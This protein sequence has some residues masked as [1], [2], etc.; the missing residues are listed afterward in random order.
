MPKL[1]IRRRAPSESVCAKVAA[2]M[3]LYRRRNGR[4]EV[5]N[6]FVFPCC[7]RTLSRCIR[8]HGEWGHLDSGVA[9]AYK[10]YVDNAYG[11]GHRF[12][13]LQYFDQD[14]ESGAIVRRQ[15]VARRHARGVRTGAGRSPRRLTRPHPFR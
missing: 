5:R 9:M 12:E 4:I 1:S 14:D 11:K 7:P 6:R 13:C 10:G 2:P 3:P 15:Q 8:G